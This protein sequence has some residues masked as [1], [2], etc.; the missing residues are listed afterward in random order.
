[1]AQIRIANNLEALQS[2]ISTCRA[3][4]TQLGNT[5]KRSI[6]E[7]NALTGMWEGSAHDVFLQQFQTD[8]ENMQKLLDFVDS[9][10]EDLERARQKYA[11][12]ESD[13][14]ERIR[15]III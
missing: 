12:C 7:V 3:V 2:D 10:L 15:T 14:S 6:E 1:M 4:Q 5:F 13:V 8:A 9:Y 11:G